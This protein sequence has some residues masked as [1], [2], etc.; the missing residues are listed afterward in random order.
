MKQKA[1]CIEPGIPWRLVSSNDTKILDGRFQTGFY[2]KCLPAIIRR[3]M[4]TSPMSGDLSILCVAQNK[5]DEIDNQELMRKV[6]EKCERTQ[7]I[8]DER[9][10]LHAELSAT[11]REIAASDAWLRVSGRL[12]AVKPA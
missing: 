5:K 12:L 1:S 6:E 8:E 9:L 4:P 7:A 11:L 2:S 3:E 10:A